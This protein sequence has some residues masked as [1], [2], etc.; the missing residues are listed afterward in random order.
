MSIDKDIVR[1]LCEKFDLTDE[2]INNA[3][4]ITN[5]LLS[6]IEFIQLTIELE[7]NFDI[8]FI[9]ADYDA[10]NFK[11]ISSMTNLIKQKLH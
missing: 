11:N 9:E 6:S 4:S 1:I 7:N 2:I 5:V 3:D 8:E 10:E